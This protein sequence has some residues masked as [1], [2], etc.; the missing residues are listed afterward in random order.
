VGGFAYSGRIALRSKFVFGDVVRGRVFVAD[1]AAMKKADDGI[2]QTV[3]PVEELQLY[4]TPAAGTYV[5]PRA[6]PGGQRRDGHSRRPAHRL[7]PRRRV[8]PHVAA[9]WMDQD[10]RARSVGSQQS[11]VGSQRSVVR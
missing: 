8:V 2:P 10:A 9:G 7:E 3:A 6:R 11:A 1:T 5:V 4:A